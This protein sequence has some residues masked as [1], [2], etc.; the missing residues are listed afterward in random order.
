MRDL[1]Y[2]CGLGIKLELGR[3]KFK[4][5]LSHETHGVPGPV[6]LCQEHRLESAF[7]NAHGEADGL[8]LP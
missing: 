5:Q 1:N 8:G 6:G 7:D 4:L 3:A 2:A